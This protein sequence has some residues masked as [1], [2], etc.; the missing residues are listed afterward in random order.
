MSGESF[1]QAVDVL[2]VL[3]I[4]TRRPD[5]RVYPNEVLLPAGEAGLPA[6]SIILAHQIRTVSKSRVKRTIGYL[7][8][9]ETRGLVHD[10]LSFHLELYWF[11]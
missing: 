1:N 3:P 4:T 8:D 9:R 2:T 7:T 10:A 11:E 5:R 6:E